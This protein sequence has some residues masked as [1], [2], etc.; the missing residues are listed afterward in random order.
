MKQCPLLAGE[1]KILDVYVTGEAISL[2]GTKQIILKA[3][4]TGD[5]KIAALSVGSGD[6]L[7]KSME[8][9]AADLR[10][11]IAGIGTKDAGA[12]GKWRL[13]INP[14][15]PSNPAAEKIAE[16]RSLDSMLMHALS[17]RA[18]FDLVDTKSNDIIAGENMLAVA[19]F[20][21]GAMAPIAGDYTHYVTAT[22]AAYDDTRVLSYQVI[23]SKTRTAV[24]SDIKEWTV[25]QNPEK[26]LDEVA[27]TTENDVMKVLGKVEILS[28]DP[29]DAVVT[30]EF[31]D[32]SQAK[33]VNH[34]KSPLLI[35][36]IPAGDYTVYFTHEERNTLTKAITVKAVETLKLGKIVLPDIDMSLFQQ[37]SAAEGGGKY[38]D[39][40]S[41]YSQFYTKYP[42]HRMASYAMYREGYV[43]QLR[44]KK[45]A[46]GRKILETVIARQPDAE[47]RSEAYVG[48]ALGYKAEGD[49]EKANGIFRMLTD[50]YA[51]TTA[52]EFARECLEGKCSF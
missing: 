14:V 36:D 24:I 51:G 30:F 28:C 26:A 11:K 41:L 47:I 32:P 15:R 13:A 35:E 21:P 34:C 27:E 18:V 50:Q 45:V 4:K 29:V 22:I 40:N 38:A 10:K 37:A 23:S 42:K 16:L 33:K 17:K 48:M 52:A 20:A 46:D 3:V 25:G 31:K 39:A 44:L 8:R 12:S 6:T 43:T 19:G 7:E 1:M 49:G 9:A 5:Q 2:A